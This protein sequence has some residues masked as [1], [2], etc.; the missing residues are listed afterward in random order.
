MEFIHLLSTGVLLAL[1]APQ[2]YS[3]L[4]KTRTTFAIHARAD[5]LMFAVWS[6]GF[7]PIPL[8][9]A[10]LASD[11]LQWNLKDPLTSSVI[12][13]KT[14]ECWW[15]CVACRSE[16][17]WMDNHSVLCCFG[18]SDLHLRTQISLIPSQEADGQKWSWCN[19]DQAKTSLTVSHLWISLD[20]TW[21][22]NWNYIFLPY[23]TSSCVFQHLQSKVVL[24][25][26]KKQLFRLH[27]AFLEIKS[28]MPD[29]VGMD[30]RTAAFLYAFTW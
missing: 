18:C 19:G 5:T 30:D 2:T 28:V 10:R 6:E 11:E 9:C 13:S 8:G 16:F 23:N 17:W 7:V 1:A 25:C 26:S 29:K 12:M 21:K 4:F 24:L 22:I 20:L 3:S 27:K 14:R 15:G